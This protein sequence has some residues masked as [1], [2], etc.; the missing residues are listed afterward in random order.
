MKVVRTLIRKTKEALSFSSEKVSTVSQSWKRGKHRKRS[1]HSS[2]V[3]GTKMRR[4]NL[5]EPDYVYFYSLWRLFYFRWGSM[6]FRSPEPFAKNVSF[7]AERR[8]NIIPFASQT[9]Q[10][11]SGVNELQ[12][13][14]GD[15]FALRS[16][17]AS[18]SDMIWSGQRW[19][20][21]CGSKKKSVVMSSSQNQDICVGLV[22]RH[23]HLFFK[24]LEKQF[25]K[26]HFHQAA[27]INKTN[28]HR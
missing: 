17:C 19:K 11:Y 26:R 3:K 16:K 10:S 6:E 28:Q 15:T 21:F 20:L 12:Q 18:D 25:D 9:E 27:S 4:I 23:L 22:S 14:K 7:C 24:C 1:R 8:Y 2:P 13:S 5:Q